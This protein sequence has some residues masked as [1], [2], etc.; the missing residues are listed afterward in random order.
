M[1]ISYQNIFHLVFDIKGRRG[2]VATLK[3][4]AQES[5]RVIIKRIMNVKQ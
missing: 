3:P 2:L 1:F 4:Q 5:L